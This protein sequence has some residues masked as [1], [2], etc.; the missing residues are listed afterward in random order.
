MNRKGAYF[1]MLVAVVLYGASW[2]VM[3]VGLAGST[4]LWFAAARAGAGTVVILIGLGLLGRLR[5]PYRHD[6]PLIASISLVQMAAFYALTMIGL[7]LVPA[8]RS[9]VIAYTTSIWVVPLSLLLGE[10]LGWRKLTGVVLGLVGV[11]IL[12]NPAAI[13]WSAPG[14]LLGHA[15]LLLSALAWATAILH[16]RHHVWSGSSLDILPYQMGLAAVALALLAAVMEPHGWIGSEPETI[17]SVLVVGGIVGP[18]GS[19]CATTVQRDLPSLVTSLGFLGVPV[20]G[21]AI[22]TL[23]LGEPI[24]FALSIGGLLILAGVALVSLAGDR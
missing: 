11:G 24:G 7:Q 22:S 3:K 1:A 6:L 21:V 16:S 14:A 20:L 4:P 10:R 8:G 15:L 2:P 9:V 19:W 23:W 12:L 13:D 18:I 17:L 5:L